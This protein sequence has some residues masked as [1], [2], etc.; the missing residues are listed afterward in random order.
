MSLHLQFSYP[1]RTLYVL[2]FWFANHWFTTVLSYPTLKTFFLDILL[3]GPCP[4]IVLSSLLSICSRPRPYFSV[5]SCLAYCKFISNLEDIEQRTVSPMLCVSNS[6]LVYPCIGLSFPCPLVCF[7]FVLELSLS[8]CL[9]PQ[10]VPALSCLSAFLSSVYSRL[11][12]A[13]LSV[14]TCFLYSQ[15][16]I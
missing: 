7:H 8:C 1:T 4:C 11:V 2:D 5:V 12:P 14:F 15:L 6:R 16:F 3:W 13:A 9:Y 10:F